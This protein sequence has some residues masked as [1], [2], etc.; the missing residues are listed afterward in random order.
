MIV[1][2][3]SFSVGHA[4]QNSSINF[5]YDLNGNRILRQIIIGNDDKDNAYYAGAD[6][7]VMDSVDACAIALFPNPTK[8]KFSISIND[9]ETDARLRATIISTTGEIVYDKPI[10]KQDEEFDLTRQPAGIYLFRLLIGNESYMWKV[11]K[12]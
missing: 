7:P 11:I 8:G 1:L 9:M 12:K 2:C 6:I 5:S 3:V 4:Q 10:Y